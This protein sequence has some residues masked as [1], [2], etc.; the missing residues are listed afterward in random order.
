MYN[1]ITILN[2]VCG[3]DSINTSIQYEH[4]IFVLHDSHSGVLYI[5]VS[6]IFLSYVG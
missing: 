5:A 4:N 2:L 3:W 1:Y 6:R